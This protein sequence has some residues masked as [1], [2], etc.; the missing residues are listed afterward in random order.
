MSEPSIWK[1][2]RSDIIS[3]F[4]LSRIKIPT[5]L[6]CSNLTNNPVN[7]PLATNKQNLPKKINK[8]C[9]RSSYQDKIR[10]KNNN[11]DIY[12][13]ERS[14]K[15]NDT[16]WICMCCPYLDNSNEN[17]NPSFSHQGKSQICSKKYL[18]PAK[19]CQEFVGVNFDNNKPIS[20]IYNSKNP[21]LQEVFS[22]SEIGC[23]RLLLPHSMEQ[24]ERIYSSKQQ[25]RII[26]LG[27]SFK[28]M[29]TMT[30]PE[31][32]FIQNSWKTCITAPPAYQMK[33]L[34]NEPFNR[35]SSFCNS[36]SNENQSDISS[37]SSSRKSVMQD[38]IANVYSNCAFEPRNSFSSKSK[39]NIFSNST[40]TNGK[41]NS[42]S[43]DSSVASDAMMA[44]NVE[45]DYKWRPLDL[46]FKIDFDSEA[47]FPK[48][49]VVDESNSYIYNI[50]SPIPPEVTTA[51]KIGHTK[52]VL[53]H[54]IG[55]GKI[56]SIKQPPK[57]STLGSCYNIKKKLPVPGE[58]FV[59]E[60]WKT[61]ITA[62]PAYQM[63]QLL[64]ESYEFS[65][66]CNSNSSNNHS[67]NSSINST[68]S[69][70]IQDYMPNI[71]SSPKFKPNNGFSSKL[72]SSVYSNSTI[73]SEKSN[74]F[75]SRS[76][77]S[78]YSFMDN[79]VENE[80]NWSPINFDNELDIFSEKEFPKL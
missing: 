30:V 23:E 19:N 32:S 63:E 22:E 64:G 7:S 62:P 24:G 37:T 2:R 52:L 39:P 15:E 49:S 18:N 60:S 51:S 34:Q 77:V 38:Y 11:I 73:T 78:N 26:A 56:F 57:T 54:S 40:F 41:S 75:S 70:L 55:R 21:V 48:L 47:E 79:D 61:L 44:C 4:P 9:E 36:N 74:S 10:N 33:K 8:N 71:S 25:M 1:S 67:G 20:N 43:S 76:S 53:P 17:I 45:N 42:F 6:V 50:R 35:F 14:K 69:S 16:E 29:E 31:K 27:S 66:Y 46:D 68:K 12:I 80:Y 5:E 13:E 59:Q 65:S 28:N 3:K 72:N 58:G